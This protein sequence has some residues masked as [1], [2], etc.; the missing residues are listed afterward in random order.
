MRKAARNKSAARQQISS[1]VSYQAPTGGWNAYDALADM[2]PTEAI[3][4]DNWYPQTQYCEIRGGSAISSTGMTGIGKTLMVYNALSGTNKMFCS[5]SS[6]VYNVS[7]PGV[8]AASVASR[9]N[10]KHQHLIFGDGTNQ[11]LIMVNGVDAPLYYDG[12]T[13]LAV[14]GVSSP[15]LTGPADITK[16]ISIFIFKSRLIFLEKNTLKFWY[17]SAGV[18]GGALTAFDLSGVAQ[19]GGYLMAA[20]SWTVDAGNGVDDR[21]VFV[22]S[23]GEVIVYQGTNPSSAST[24][25]LV[26]VYNIGEPIGRNC[27]LR[28][29]SELIFLTKNGS[30]P[31]STVWQAS[32]LDYSK[33]VTRKIQKAFNSAAVSYGSNFGWKAISYPAQNAVLI[34]IPVAEDGVHY[35]YVMNSLNNSWCRFIGWDAE[36]FALFNGELY[37]CQGTNTIKCWTGTADQGANINAYAKTAFSYFGSK[38]QNKDFKMFRP[39]LSVNG[40]LNFLVD[41]DVD[42]ADAEIFGTATYTVNSAGSWDVGNW[43]QAFWSSGL[44]IIK[45]WASP[46]SWTGY[47]AA[48]K[49]KIST[50]SLNVQWMSVDYVYE[51]GGGL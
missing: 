19:M 37:Y 9:T 47:C 22:T 42:F 31:L 13:W 33:A 4:L 24:W 27:I 10:G 43:D 12:T 15:A 32:G 18:A 26:G 1:F 39:V 3:A 23:N 35:Q 29:G 11:Y 28:V 34:N 48:G 21:A 16:L 25:A 20:E 2:Q 45:N 51:V 7:S 40:S 8:V 30:Y 5:T 50:N 46:S 44:Q 6:G 14:T 36:D 17:L 41:M 49:M 38:G